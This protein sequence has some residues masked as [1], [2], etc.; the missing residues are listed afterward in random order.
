[1]DLFF[2]LVKLEATKLGSEV[3]RGFEDLVLLFSIGSKLGIRTGLNGGSSG[4]SSGVG[5][6]IFDH[7]HDARNGIFEISGGFFVA[8][9]I[10]VAFDILEEDV[11]SILGDGVTGGVYSRAWGLVHVG[12]VLVAILPIVVTGLS[13]VVLL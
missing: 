12:S 10:D 13:V 6:G 7:S 3:T 2:N 1:M 5:D 4:S 8:E 11:E 9:R